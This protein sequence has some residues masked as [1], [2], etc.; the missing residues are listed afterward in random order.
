MYTYNKHFTV[1]K[2][3]CSLHFLYEIFPGTSEVTQNSKHGPFSVKVTTYVTNFGYKIML[4]FNDN[5]DVN[6]NSIL[7]SIISVIDAGN[8]SITSVNDT[9]DKLM[10][11]VNDTGKKTLHT[12]ISR[13]IKLPPFRQLTD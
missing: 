3:Y 10:T 8:K 5:V 7:K 1:T 4:S 6:E 13:H 9:V 12:N 2:A 11:G